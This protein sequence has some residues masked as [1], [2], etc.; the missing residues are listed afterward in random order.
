[1]RAS[2][3]AR[4]P[5]ERTAVRSVS[6]CDGQRSTSPYEG[7]SIETVEK[8]WRLRQI[9]PLCKKVNLMLKSEQPL[10]N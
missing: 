3:D 2:Y 6:E 7:S 5:F 1:L 10:L 9:V 4:F 8:L